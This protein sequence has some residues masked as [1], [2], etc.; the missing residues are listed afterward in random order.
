MRNRVI[1]VLALLVF[2]GTF[3]VADA[4]GQQDKLLDSLTKNRTQLVLKDGKFTGTG[5][6]VLE[7]ALAESQFVLIG[8]E[9]GT[10]QVP[11]FASAVC[12]VVGPLGFH[13]MAVEAGPRAVAAMQPWI[14]SKNGREQLAQFEKKFPDTIAF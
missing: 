12:N 10:E 11:A 9:H 4:L 6:P 5:A 2:V 13:T 3:C 14:E 1:F 7:K 8:E